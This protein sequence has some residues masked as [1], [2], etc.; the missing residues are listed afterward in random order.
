MTDL[1]GD[2]SACSV[3]HWAGMAHLPVDLL[4]EPDQEPVDGWLNATPREAV[5]PERMRDGAVIVAGWGERAWRT[6]LMINGIALAVRPPEIGV[7]HGDTAPAEW[8]ARAHAVLAHHLSQDLDEAMRA[9]LVNQVLALPIDDFRRQH[10][11]LGL[12]LGAHRTLRRC[13][14]RV[15]LQN[16][17]NHHLGA[18]G[19]PHSAPTWQVLARLTRTPTTRLAGNTSRGV[20][21]HDSQAQCPTARRWT[22]G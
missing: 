14:R 19:P 16:V 4:V 5:R 1:R 13:A 20:L 8:V 3:A 7:D 15:L 2:G 18:S 9:S 22:D 10:R 21:I 6:P 17:A 12:L 11:S